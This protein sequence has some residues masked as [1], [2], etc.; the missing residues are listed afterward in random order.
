MCTKPLQRRYCR[1]LCTGISLIELIMFIL[2][3]SIGVVGI[4]S[5]FNEAVR[6]SADP[7]RRKQAIAIAETVLTEI[8]Q[9]PF[10]YCDPQDATFTTAAN[11]T[12]GVGGCTATSQDGGGGGNGSVVAGP[13]GGGRVTFNNVADY[14]G[15]SEANISDILGGNAMNG[16]TA[17]VVITRAGGDFPLIP[18]PGDALRIQVTVTFGTDAPIV[19]TGFRFRFAPNG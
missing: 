12:V 19:L 13:A 10:T 2:V 17:T 18:G 4:L 15:W 7:M 3:V 5:V 14:A 8:E 6:G 11:A 9:Q 1:H 16:Y